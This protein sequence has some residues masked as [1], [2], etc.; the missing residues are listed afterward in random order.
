MLNNQN[1]KITVLETVLSD[2]QRDD[3][4]AASRRM[5]AC[6]CNPEKGTGNDRI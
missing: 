4:F 1:K 6:A 3:F 2:Y 5:N